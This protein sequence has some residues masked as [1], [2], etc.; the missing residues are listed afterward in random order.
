MA[1]LVTLILLLIYF[2]YLFIKLFKEMKKEYSAK[3]IKLIFT[4]FCFVFL[5]ENI[6]NGFI[7]IAREISK[8]FS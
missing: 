5:V 6:I 4:S 3:E 8:L 7:E 1:N 2:I